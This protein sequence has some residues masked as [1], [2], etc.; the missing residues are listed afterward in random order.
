M[1]ASLLP[2]LRGQVSQERRF[3]GTVQATDD[4]LD[5]VGSEDAERL[6]EKGTSCP[7]HFLRTKIKPLYV[8]WDPQ[9]GSVAGLKETL[10][11]GLEDYRADYH[12]YYETCSERDPLRSG[13]EVPAMRDPNPTVILIPGLGM[14]AWGKSK[15]ESRVTAEFYRA[16]IEVMKGAEAVSEYTAISRQEAYDIEY[17]RLEIAKLERR[18][19]EEELSRRIVAVIGAGSGIGRALAGRLAEEK[20]TLALLDLNGES[21]EAA[22]QDIQEQVG[23]GIGVAG[24]GISGGGPAIGV[25]CDVTDRASVQ[26][27]LDDVALAYGGLDHVAVTAGFYKSTPAGEHTGQTAANGQSGLDDVWDQS[28]A[29]NAK[30]V[31]VAADEAACVLREQDLGGASLV[32][33]TSANAVVPKSGSFAYDAS[34]AAANHLIRE[35]AIELAPLARVNGVAPATV[36][37]GSSM[38]PRERVLRSLDKYGLDYDDS[39]ETPALRERLAEFYAERTLTKRPITPAHQAEAIYMM[40]SDARSAQTTGQV[41][42]VDGGLTEAFLR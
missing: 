34:K 28:F 10:A 33:T 23:F 41:L 19:P 21:A 1:L 6:A 14:V 31:F 39:D 20:A 7:D 13:D 32:V 15:S 2:W 4:V 24:T 9:T 22:A 16:A 11:E 30:G 27:A 37:Q 40:L 3:I 38:F 18:P 26:K 17:W 25:G 35:L 42:A 5:F 29:V 36:V 8:D 12:A